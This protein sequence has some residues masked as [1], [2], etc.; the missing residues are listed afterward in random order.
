MSV[1][2]AECRNY[3]HYTECRYYECHYAECRGATTR[4]VIEALFM[5]KN[6]KLDFYTLAKNLMSVNSIDIFVTKIN[7]LIVKTC[8]K[9]K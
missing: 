8:N 5:L 1:I 9:S 6:K 2:Y 4:G 7:F 3:T